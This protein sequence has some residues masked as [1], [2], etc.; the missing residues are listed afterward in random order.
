MTCSGRGAVRRRGA[1][2]V[3]AAL[4]IGLLF[5]VLFG[6]YEYGRLLMVENMVE[7]AAREGARSAIVQFTANKSQAELDAETD[8]VRAAVLRAMAGLDSQIDGLRIDVVRADPVTGAD[9]GPW[10]T[11]QYGEPIAVRITGTYRP[12][13]RFFLPAVVPVR[14]QSTMTSEAN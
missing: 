8:Q 7:H 5:L 3:E 11:A 6:V 4:V 13:L 2:V 12:A 1:S 14:V 10:Y 9:A